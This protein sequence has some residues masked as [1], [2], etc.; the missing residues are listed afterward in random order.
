MLTLHADVTRAA[1]VAAV[2][3]LAVGGRVRVLAEH[4]PEHVLPGNRHHG[5]GVA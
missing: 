4:D 3:A 2:L 1:R 5:H